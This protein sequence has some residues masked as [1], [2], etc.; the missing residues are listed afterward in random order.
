MRVVER[1]ALDRDVL[2]AREHVELVGVD[3]DDHVD[4]ARD[5]CRDAGRELR[6]L[7]EE[8]ARGR[9][10]AAEVLIVGGE[11]DMPP[12]AP[13]LELV[14]AGADRVAK[15]VVEAGLELGLAVAV[16]LGCLA[17]VLPGLLAD[18]EGAVGRQP[19]LEDEVRSLGG[20]AHGVGIERLDLL[21]MA[22]ILAPV[23]QRVLV[24]HALAGEGEQHVVGGE[25]GAVGKLHALAEL[26]G[27]LVRR[28]PLPGLGQRR[29]QARAAAFQRVHEV[30]T[31]QRVEDR[32]DDAHGDVA[33]MRQ[34]L[35]AGR[36][37][38]HRDRQIRARLGRSGVD[39]GK[40]G[41]DGENSQT[42]SAHGRSP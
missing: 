20:E 39:Q 7:A 1:H 27:H 15:I 22:E 34:R 30:A 31:Q 4:L 23:Q 26:E 14:G 37:L 21:E 36:Q 17:G 19:L 12:L 5:E 3:V 13:F 11:L 6:D 42:A 8:H 29:Q 18:D 41:K 24:E 38:V 2:V 10:L 33:V 28:V 32:V 9:G 40:G 25:V 35:H 16:R